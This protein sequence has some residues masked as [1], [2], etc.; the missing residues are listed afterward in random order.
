[1]RIKKMIVFLAAFFLGLIFV[2]SSKPPAPENLSVVARISATPPVVI[3]SETETAEEIVDW[4][5]EDESKFKIKLLETGE[6]FHGDEVEAKSGETWL[7][8]F[9][10]GDR[11]FLRST[12]LK[13]RRVH[14]S[15][16]D[17]EKQKTGKSVFT[18]NKSEAVFLL[19][20]AKLPSESE[21]KTIFFAEDYDKAIEFK[22]GSEK[23]FE[24]NGKSYN[25][26]V[27][28]KLTS[29][30]FLGKGSKL[31]L[32]HNGKEQT[33]SYLAEGC[34]DCYWYL[35]WIGDLDKDGK[36]DFYFNLS[37]HYNVSDKRLFLSSPAEKGKLVKNVASFRTTGC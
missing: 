8:L 10:E 24:F 22:N 18:N 4:Q 3:K 16:V 20:N 32:S 36:A 31:I 17:N 30:E 2:P 5:E 34:N 14:D 26:R 11:Y 33:L 19:K 9:Q 21:V 12:K 7:G 35:Y 6:G 25:L 28:N 29:E 1:M 37:P 13:I 23:N 27:E 15:I